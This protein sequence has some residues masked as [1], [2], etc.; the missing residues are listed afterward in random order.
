MGGYFRTYEL[1]YAL[2]NVVSALS[3][4]STFEEM[5]ARVSQVPETTAELVELTNYINES[6]DATMFNL[7]TKLIATAE[8][9]MF[10]LSHALLQSQ[11]SCLP[12]N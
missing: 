10:L 12:T 11:F 7:K 2:T 1:V 5:A 4:A 6:R 9:V 3:I 8:Y